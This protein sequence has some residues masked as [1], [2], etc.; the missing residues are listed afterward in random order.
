M[1]ENLFFFQLKI[2]HLTFSLL[3]KLYLYLINTKKIFSHCVKN[4]SICS[5]LAK[6]PINV[7]NVAWRIT[8]FNYLFLCRKNKKKCLIF[9]MKTFS[10]DFLLFYKLYLYSIN[11]H[12]KII[13]C[14]KNLSICS[15]LA[16]TALNVFNIAW[17][18][19]LFNYLSCYRKNV[20]LFF[21]SQDIVSYW[22]FMF[23]TWCPIEVENRVK[24][25]FCSF[26][27]RY[28]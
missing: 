10:F 25:C 24:H 12:K 8:L 7:F 18:L 3:Y 26:F 9:S 19:A 1:I 16:K 23:R 5:T 22:N 15:T 28:C 14:V 4:L 27:F 6:A 17:R 11:T 20:L 13:H 2:F 21:Q